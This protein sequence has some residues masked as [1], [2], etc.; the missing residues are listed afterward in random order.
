MKVISR[1]AVE[2]SARLDSSDASSRIYGVVCATSPRDFPPRL[3]PATSRRVGANWLFKGPESRYTPIV[4]LA[5]F[6]LA[7]VLQFSLCQLPLP[8]PPPPPTPLPLAAAAVTRRTASRPHPP[9]LAEPKSRG[10]DERQARVLSVTA[11]FVVGGYAQARPARDARR[12]IFPVESRRLLLASL[13][14]AVSSALPVNKEP[15]GPR[16]ASGPR[17][18]DLASML[19]VGPADRGAASSG[20]QKPDPGI[21]GPTAEPRG[22]PSLLSLLTTCLGRWAAY[23]C[24]SGLTTAR[25]LGRGEVARLPR[26]RLIRIAWRGR[27]GGGAV[28]ALRRSREGRRGG[29]SGAGSDP[30]AGES[31]SVGRAH[32]V[33]TG[34]GAPATR[35]E[36][37]GFKRHRSQVFW[38]RMETRDRTE[39]TLLAPTEEC[40]AEESEPSEP[41]EPENTT[42]IHV[43][44]RR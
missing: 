21:E 42:V 37:E 35:I 16:Q 12:A 25:R 22:C 18:Q 24:G 26:P 13:A 27:A 4:R 7:G 40:H 28:V 6:S 2:A 36:M 3:P 31:Q 34:I 17:L 33:R 1:P 38:G 41:S 32:D 43:E 15:H 44:S 9:R 20:V 30:G 19:G 5:S 23:G 10:L 29:G 14:R 39:P 11:A 8:P